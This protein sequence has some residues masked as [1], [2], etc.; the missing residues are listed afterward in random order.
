M[1]FPLIFLT[2][3][4]LSALSLLI[5]RDFQPPFGAAACHLALVNQRERGRVRRDPVTPPTPRPLL[6]AAPARRSC[7]G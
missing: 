1:R 2:L 6:R 5:S 7:S 3:V 4:T